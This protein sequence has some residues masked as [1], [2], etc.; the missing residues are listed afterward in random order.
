MRE[1]LKSLRE[2]V[3][4]EN[5]EEL[6]FYQLRLSKW[7]ILLQYVANNDGGRIFNRVTRIGS[8]IF[9]FLGVRQFFVL[10]VSKRTRMFVLY[11]KS[12][13]FF[14]QDKKWVNS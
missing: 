12:K 8:H 2:T 10:K 13:V 9:G 11:M 14:I 5:E 4:G 7:P 6:R 3:L 1:N